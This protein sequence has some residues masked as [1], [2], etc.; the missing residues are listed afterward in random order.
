MASQIQ[1]SRREKPEIL[2]SIRHQTVQK[3]NQELAKY[4]S[5]HISTSTTEDQHL[6]GFLSLVNGPAEAP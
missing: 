1:N 3:N 2:K 6:A 5:S 4:N